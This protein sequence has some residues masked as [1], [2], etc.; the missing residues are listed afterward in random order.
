[1]FDL[2]PE[3]EPKLRQYAARLVD[4]LVSVIGRA[5]Q[6]LS[7]AVVSF[8]FG[9]AGFAMNRREPGTSGIK[10]GLNPSGPSDHQVPVVLVAGPDGRKRAI[11]FAYACHNTTLT[12]DFYQ[13]GRRLRRLRGGQT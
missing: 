5:I 6:D 11:L 9:E 13:I 3:E 7:P 12:G 2:R 1:M 8:G 4:D 10:I